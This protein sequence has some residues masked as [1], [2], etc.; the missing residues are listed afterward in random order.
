[1]SE[2]PTLATIAA[3]VGVSTATVSK[4]VNGR[5][6]VGADTRARVEQALADHGYV[7]VRRKARQVSPDATEFL[8]TVLSAATDA[9]LEVVITITVRR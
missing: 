2:R 8:R 5:P 3:G 6:D 9:E 1:M 4:V 7:P